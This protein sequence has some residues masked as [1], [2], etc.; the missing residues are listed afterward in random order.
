MHGG[1]GG[2]KA[3]STSVMATTEAERVELLITA[4]SPKKSPGASMRRPMARPSR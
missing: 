3:T 4:I 2:R 1:A